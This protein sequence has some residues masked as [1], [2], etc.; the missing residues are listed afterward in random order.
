MT[1][2]P[3]LPVFDERGMTILCVLQ[4]VR[5]SAKGWYEVGGD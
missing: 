3:S 2:I 5:I 1:E 4:L